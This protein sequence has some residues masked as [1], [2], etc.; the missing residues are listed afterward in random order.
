[1]M[2]VDVF[3]SGKEIDLIC[4]D[5]ATIEHTNWYKW[6]NDEET[7][8]FMQRHYYPNTKQNQIDFYRASIE[9]NQSKVQLGIFHKKAQIMIG[10]ISLNNIDFINSNCEVS[11]VIGEK[12]FQNLRNL[13]EA[14]KLIIRHAFETMNLHRVYGGSLIKEIDLLFCRALGY[15]SEGCLKQQVYKNGEYLD[16]YLFGILREKYLKL[17]DNWFKI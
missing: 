1:M 13:V 17:R 7:T 8:K 4:L 6:F 15:S 5:E 16:V 10:A 9:K 3:I 11:L 14:H 12:D 2:N